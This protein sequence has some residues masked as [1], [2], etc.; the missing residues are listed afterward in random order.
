MRIR[1]IYQSTNTPLDELN[2][3]V[4]DKDLAE[5]LGVPGAAHEL[6]IIASSDDSVSAMQS[7]YEK[8]SRIRG[9]NPGKSFRLKQS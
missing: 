7:R 8:S 3:Y 4:R 6:V 1:G 9:W 5:L 2:I